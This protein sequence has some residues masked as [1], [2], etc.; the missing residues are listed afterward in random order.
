[1]AQL[2][3]YNFSHGFTMVG[4]H[5]L[6][7]MFYLYGISCDS[8]QVNMG[9]FFYREDYISDWWLIGKQ[10]CSTKPVGSLLVID[11][12]SHTKKHIRI[13]LHTASNLRQAKPVTVTYVKY[14]MEGND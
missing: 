13:M 3:F 7:S 11:R 5:T 4:W 9:G 12:F 10:F 6:T 1:M 8:L 14:Y 2:P